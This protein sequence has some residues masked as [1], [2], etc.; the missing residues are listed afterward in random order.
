M[1]RLWQTI[2][3]KRKRTKEGIKHEYEK[4]Q[5]S[6][7][8]RADRSARTVARRKANR[9]G[10]T[11]KGDGKEIDHIKGLSEGGS[12]RSS[13]TRVIS[14]EANRSRRQSSRKRGSTRNRSRWGK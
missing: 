9:S 10:R 14:R 7:K 13:N 4:F 5:S 11:H 8:A 1:G 12:K 3:G 6:A 2:N